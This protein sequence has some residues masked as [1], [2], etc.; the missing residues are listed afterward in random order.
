[1]TLAEITDWLQTSSVWVEFV[2]SAMIAAQ[3]SFTEFVE[4][5]H[6]KDAVSRLAHTKHNLHPDFTFVCLHTLRCWTC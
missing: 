4:Q 1:M 6:N 2:L 3:A 5:V